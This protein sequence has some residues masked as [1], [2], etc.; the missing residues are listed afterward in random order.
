MAPNL[1][2]DTFDAE[3]FSAGRSVSS[4]L[5]YP[6]AFIDQPF[7]YNEKYYQFY[8][9]ALHRNRSNSI[10]LHFST[11]FSE[12]MTVTHKWDEIW[13]KLFY[14]TVIKN[15]RNIQWDNS[16]PYMSIQQP[17][18]LQVICRNTLRRFAV[19]QNGNV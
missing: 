7:T 18:E 14:R 12:H 16:D 10:E 1:S 8:D 4:L 3:E 15:K 11:I 9:T 2:N 17:F 13:N 5:L 6:Q 19:Q